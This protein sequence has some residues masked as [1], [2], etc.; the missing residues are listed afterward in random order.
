MTKGARQYQSFLKAA[1]RSTGVSH[2]EAQQMYR[3]MSERIG[4]KASAKDVKAHPRITK[5]EA[6]KAIFTKEVTGGGKRAGRGSRG[7]GGGGG[8]GVGGAGGGGGYYDDP[9]DMYEDDQW[10]DFEDPLQ[11]TGGDS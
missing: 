9:F 2:K 10:Y 7:A 1:K 6:N 3:T 11:D 5:Q 4:H 8:G